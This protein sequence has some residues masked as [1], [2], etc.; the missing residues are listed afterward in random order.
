MRKLRFGALIPDWIPGFSTHVIYKGA[1]TFVRTLANVARES[2]DMEV[3]RILDV[4]QLSECD[5]LFIFHHTHT[6]WT[7]Y[8]ARTYTL[9]YLHLF[10]HA[11]EYH[12]HKFLWN[13]EPIPYFKSAHSAFFNPHCD[14]IL[15]SS[16]CPHLFYD[17]FD[18]MRGTFLYVGNPCTLDEPKP[19]LSNAISAPMTVEE[20]ARRLMYTGV[21]N[22]DYSIGTGDRVSQ[23]VAMYGD[24]PIEIHCY[25]KGWWQIRDKLPK[26]FHFRPIQMNSGAYDPYKYVLEFAELDRAALLNSIGWHSDRLGLALSSSAQLVSNMTW[27]QSFYSSIRTHGDFATYIRE[28]GHLPEAETEAIAA[29]RAAYNYRAVVQRLYPEIVRRIREHD[30]SRYSD[31]TTPPL[32]G[33]VQEVA[34]GE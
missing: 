28:Y 23:L 13:V 2:G 20:N 8:E 27:S 21:L 30:A 19:K 4:E 1:Y 29:D 15:Y 14:T 6:G 5:G 7:Q 3:F 11:N 16:V 17:A 26:N 33:S 24:L 22:D 18:H 12:Q 32:G 10:R 34:E 25:G 9:P 31:Q